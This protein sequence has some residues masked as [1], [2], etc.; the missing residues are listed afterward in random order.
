M[1]TPDS[2]PADAGA[3][4]PEAQDSRASRS[5]RA[6]EANLA[7]QLHPPPKSEEPAGIEIAGVLATVWLDGDGVRMDVD[8]RAIESWLLGQDGTVPLRLTAGDADLFTG[9]LRPP[10]QSGNPADG[11]TPGK[12]RIY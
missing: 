11:Q 5:A 2:V 9:H 10:D 6:L 8:L 1:D 4:G 7:A 12:A 3:P